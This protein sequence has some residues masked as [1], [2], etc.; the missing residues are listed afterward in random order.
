MSADAADTSSLVGVLRPEELVQAADLRKLSCHQ[1]LDHW[2]ENYWQ[3]SWDLP[4]GQSYD[5]QTLPHPTC[6]LSVELGPSRPEVGADPVVL[7]GVVTR[8]FDVRLRGAG[9]VTAAKFRPGGLAALRG[10]TAPPG[11]AALRE[12]VVPARTLLPAGICDD[13]GRITLSTPPAE[14]LTTLEHALLSL[15]ADAP[16]DPRYDTVLAVIDDMLGD[17]DLQR[18]AQIEQRHGLSAR[19]LQRLFERYVGVGPKWVLARYRIH[20]AISELDAGYEG[21]IADLAASLGW[22]DQAHFVRDFTRLIG[23]PPDQYRRRSGTA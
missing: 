21:T 13:L 22:Y 12:R 19:T 14:A 10:A 4:P 16:D 15:A 18:V 1:D 20:D 11:A 8:R 5:S 2:V 9:L 23:E 3:L 17:R 7:T 6:T